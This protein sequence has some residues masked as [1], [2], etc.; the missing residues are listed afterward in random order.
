M[1]PSPARREHALL[2]ARAEER[3]EW[4]V[5]EA[6]LQQALLLV[7]EIGV[8][9]QL[10]GM[11]ALQLGVVQHRHRQGRGTGQAVIIGNP[12]VEQRGMSLGG[13]ACCTALPSRGHECECCS[14]GLHV[15]C[16]RGND[17]AARETFTAAL[18]ALGDELPEGADTIQLGLQRCAALAHFYLAIIS[19]YS[20]LQ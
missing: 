14:E 17:E 16:C 12:Q 20:A 1:R 9:L 4:E 10:R 18:E 6:L 13:F 3:G 5:V 8:E 19:K 7:K 2:R 11:L 15:A